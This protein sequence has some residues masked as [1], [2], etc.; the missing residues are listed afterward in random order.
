MMV[1]RSE[2]RGHPGKEVGWKRGRCVKVLG[3][4]LI[5]SCF[6]SPGI[7]GYLVE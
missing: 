6:C 5:S 1:R 7:D 4:P 3:K 2:M